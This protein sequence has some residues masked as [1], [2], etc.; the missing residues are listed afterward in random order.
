MK[1][2][3]KPMA[4]VNKFEVEDV[5]AASDIATAV[6]EGADFEAIKAAYPEATQG[7]VFTW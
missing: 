5:I 2:Y 7:V 4:I 3:E 6:T 1:I